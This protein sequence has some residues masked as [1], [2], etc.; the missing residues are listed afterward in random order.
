MMRYPKMETRTRKRRIVDAILLDVMF[1]LLGFLIA[2]V[3]VSYYPLPWDL[4][5]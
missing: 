3:L 4:F 2:V 5:S 1:M